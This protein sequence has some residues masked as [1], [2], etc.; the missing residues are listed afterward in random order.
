ML[1]GWIARRLSFVTI[2]AGNIWLQALLLPLYAAAPNPVVLGAV[3]SAVALIEA[4]CDPVRYGYQ[5]SLIP[6]ALRGRVNSAASTVVFVPM[7]L[8]SAAAGV[9]LQTAGATGTVLLFAGFMGS[10]AVLT[11]INREVR[12]VKVIS[13]LRR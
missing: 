2:I 13:A 6:D 4:A 11:S 3:A 10:L 5:L 9:L 1:A 12:G 8:G 7:W